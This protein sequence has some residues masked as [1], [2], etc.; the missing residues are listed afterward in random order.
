M[1]EFEEEKDGS[2]LQWSKINMSFIL[3]EWMSVW[4]CLF[5]GE[6]EE[7]KK[8]VKM[9]MVGKQWCPKVTC[10]LNTFKKECSKLKNTFWITKKKIRNGVFASH[11][12]I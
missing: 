3:W 9:M 11:F 10:I 1:E 7:G 2:E 12:W 4:W 6:E 8:M 5:G